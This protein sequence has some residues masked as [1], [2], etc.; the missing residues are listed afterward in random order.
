V[1]E[2]SSTAA[3]HDATTIGLETAC[4]DTNA[5]GSLLLQEGEH[6]TLI[7][8]KCCL[9]ISVH[10]GGACTSARTITTR[11][12]VL[13][14]R[15]QAIGPDVLEGILWQT[16]LAALVAHVVAINELLLRH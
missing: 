15:L 7:M 1:V 12:G 9:P 4:I 13:I 10:C 14:F 5:D 11:I 2:L 8:L 6:L 16:T 3:G